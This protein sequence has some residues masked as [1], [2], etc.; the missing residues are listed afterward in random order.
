M[1]AK[2][3]FAP[4]LLALWGIASRKRRTVAFFHRLPLVPKGQETVFW[5][6]C[7]HFHRFPFAERRSCAPF[8][9]LF[10]CVQVLSV[11]K[12]VVVQ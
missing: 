2:H 10:P 12:Y 9:P 6:I 8:G 7:G 5:A 11:V 1:H 3:S 4:F